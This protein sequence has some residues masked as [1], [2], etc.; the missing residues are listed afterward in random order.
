[1]DRRRRRGEERESKE[2]ERD[3]WRVNIG[4]GNREK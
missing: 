3:V 4:E 1:V 2:G